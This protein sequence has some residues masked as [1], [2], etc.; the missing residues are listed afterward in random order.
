MSCTFRSTGASNDGI[1]SKKIGCTGVTPSLLALCSTSHTGYRPHVE[2][3]HAD[4]A[5]ATAIGAR[6]SQLIWAYTLV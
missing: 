1:F 6:R 2:S 4:S 3:L 5:A